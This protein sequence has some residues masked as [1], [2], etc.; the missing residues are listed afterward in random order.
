MVCENTNEIKPIVYIFIYL[1]ICLLMVFLIMLSV[2]EM[3]GLK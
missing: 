2:A 3:V 1:F